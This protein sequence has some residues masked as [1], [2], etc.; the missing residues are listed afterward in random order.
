MDNHF[1]FTLE[2]DKEVASPKREEQFTMSNQ[3]KYQASDDQLSGQSRLSNTGRR[4]QGVIT[5]EQQRERKREIDKAFR[6]RR[7]EQEIKMKENL[8]ILNEEN[9]SLKREN[10]VLMTEKDSMAQNLQAAGKETQQLQS[11]I[12]TLNR[13]IAN[14]QHFVDLYSNQLVASNTSH[15]V[16]ELR[17][18]EI[19]NYILRQTDWE[20]WDSEKQLL[21]QNIA[22]LEVENKWLKL[23]HQALS[24][25]VNINEDGQQGYTA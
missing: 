24:E 18:L 9:T 4:S 19:D 13:N 22:G 11:E 21:L 8:H 17:Q 16:I 3:E 2:D 25:F 12:V 14:G 1:D 20:N 6:Q 10:Q 7:K 5:Q 15:R 23:Q